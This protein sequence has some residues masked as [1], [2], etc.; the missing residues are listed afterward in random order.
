MTRAAKLPAG[1]HEGIP[2]SSNYDAAGYGARRVGYGERPAVIVV[3][4]Q[5]A[6]TDPAFPGGRS[7]HIHRAV[8][9]TADLLGHARRRG[10]PVACCNVAWCGPGDAGH[11]KVDSIFDGSYWHGHP[12]TALDPRIHDPA[13]DVHFTKSAPSMFFQTP[14]VLFLTRQRVDTVIVTG[15]TTSGCVRATINDSFS[16]GFRTIVPEQCVGDQ[17]EQPHRDNLRDVGRRYADVVD[18]D[19]VIAWI[20][21]LAAPSSAGQALLDRGEELA[22][23]AHLR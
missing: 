22:L 1:R 16:Y 20:N 7:P 17:E 12:A 14:L 5:R 2:M 13:Y 10:I 9:R 4:F 6:F 23:A 3:D 8:E 21:E 15:C 18:A 11:W 19:E